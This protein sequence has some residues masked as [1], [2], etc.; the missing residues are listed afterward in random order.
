[1]NIHSLLATSPSFFQLFSSQSWDVC[2]CVWVWGWGWWGWWRYHLLAWFLWK[3]RGWVGEHGSFSCQFGWILVLSLLGAALPVS[4]SPA[5]Q[6][7]P[8]RQ[9][10]LRAFL[11]FAD[12]RQHHAMTSP[13][14]L[15]FGATAFGI[16]QSRQTKI[17]LM[18]PRNL[19][20]KGTCNGSLSFGCFSSL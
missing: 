9:T 10:L 19:A 18:G 16:W 7:F 3:F 11:H 14:R 4:S 15:C 2:V 17:V 1:M 13:A 6:L 12:G 20:P 8:S 5:L